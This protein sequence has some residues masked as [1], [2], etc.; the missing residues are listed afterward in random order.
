MG[1]PRFLPTLL[2]TDEA[3]LLDSDA[4]RHSDRRELDYGG[5]WLEREW[6]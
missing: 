4:E 2:H 5:G 3:G 6:T 1:L